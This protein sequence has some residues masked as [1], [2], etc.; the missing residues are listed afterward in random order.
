MFFMETEIGKTRYFR[1]G[2][3]E[4][5]DDAKI[6]FLDPLRS[7]EKLLGLDGFN[8]FQ[9]KIF[10]FTRGRKLIQARPAERSATWAAS[11]TIQV[12]KSQRSHAGSNQNVEVWDEME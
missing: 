10:N 8:M 12:A 5:F 7:V 1:T 9:R 4:S 3:S 2:W 6:L 11:P